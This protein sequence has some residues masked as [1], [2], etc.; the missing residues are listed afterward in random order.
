MRPEKAM[1]AQETR[2]RVMESTFFFVT[3]YQ[4]L[5]VPKTQELRKQLLEVDARF[6]VVKN[7]LLNKVAEER[8]QGELGTG[9]K[10]PSAVVY[11]NGDAAETAKILQKFIKENDRPHVKVGAL[12]GVVLTAEEVGELAKLPGRTQL[13]GMLVGTVAAPMT[14]LVGVFQQKVASLLYVLKAVQEKR[15]NEGA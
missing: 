2:D 7:S 12:D 11:G 1:L 14:Q 3:N 6:F 15:E 8:L 9:L 13:L 4:G 5:T 10:G